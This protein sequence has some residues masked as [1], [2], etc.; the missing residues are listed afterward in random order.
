MSTA[1]STSSTISSPSI[2][3]GTWSP[4][5]NLVVTNTDGTVDQ[6]DASVSGNTMEFGTYCLAQDDAPPAIRYL[7]RQGGTVLSVKP[8]PAIFTIV[9]RIQR[10]TTKITRK[11]IG[12]I[13][14]CSRETA[15]RGLKNLEEQGLIDVHGKTIVVFGTR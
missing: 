11:E 9:S 1:E 6:A 14:G 12:R 8:V 7:E 10:A 13:V 15:G 5:P 2:D 4:V 3:S